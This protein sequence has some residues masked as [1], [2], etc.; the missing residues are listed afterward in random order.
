MSRQRVSRPKSSFKGG[1]FGDWAAEGTR[2]DDDDDDD[3]DEDAPPPVAIEGVDG[4][5]LVGGVDG[6]DE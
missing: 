4:D 1:H 6:D 5:G 3:D 2:F